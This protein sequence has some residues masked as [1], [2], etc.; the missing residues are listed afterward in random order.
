MKCPKCAHSWTRAPKAPK[1]QIPHDET[2]P[3]EVFP[4]L[5]WNCEHHVVAG[6]AVKAH[7]YMP[8]VLCESC[9]GK[10]SKGDWVPALVAVA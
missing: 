9:K 1:I 8:V 3:G 2:F 7:Q 10:T 5:C 6:D 4:Q